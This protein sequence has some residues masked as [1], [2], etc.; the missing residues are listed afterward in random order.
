ML[1]MLLG[2]ARPTT[3]LT[4]AATTR[5]PPTA[6][7]QAAVRHLPQNSAPMVASTLS[8]ITITPSPEGV[9][10]VAV[11]VETVLDNISVMAWGAWTA[12]TLGQETAAV[13]RSAQTPH[14]KRCITVVRHRP[15]RRLL[16]WKTGRGP[17]RSRDPRRAKTRSFELRCLSETIRSWNTRRNGEMKKTCLS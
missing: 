5:P 3:G 4:T 10:G 14:R 11:A 15:V 17:P 13:W 16:V 6:P 9:R 2:I 12:A 1:Q 7:G 8:G